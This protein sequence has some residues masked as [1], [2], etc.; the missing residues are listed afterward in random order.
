MNGVEIVEKH[1]QLFCEQFD[2][3]KRVDRVAHEFFS[4]LIGCY[5]G[6]L[7]LVDHSKYKYQLEYKTIR[8]FEE[9]FLEYNFNF[10][11]L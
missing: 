1:L 4:I 9:N 10:F 8:W 2:D 7:V 11:R 6:Q 5:A 3:Q